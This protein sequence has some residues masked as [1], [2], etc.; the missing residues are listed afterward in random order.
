MLGLSFPAGK[1]LDELSK[2]AQSTDSFRVKCA[3]RSFSFSGIQNQ[4]ENYF[5]RTGSPEE[6]AAFCLR[7]VAGA[8]V[9]ATL[10]AQKDYPGLRVVFSGGVASNS[11]LR[12][13]TKPLNPVFAEPRFSTDNAM[14]VAL[15]ASRLTEVGYG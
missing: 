1:A 11:L 9:R 15:L 7:C 13:Q 14:G 6:T 3:D 2:N 8:V 4:V 12:E 10:Q 5:S